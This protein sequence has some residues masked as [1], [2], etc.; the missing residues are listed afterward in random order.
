MRENLQK[1]RMQ[2]KKKFLLSKILE[3]WEPNILLDF[4]LFD[5]LSIQSRFIIIHSKEE[6]KQ[7]NRLR[8]KLEI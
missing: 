7:I 6:E 5:L 2:R 8:K 1:F 3:K 4:L